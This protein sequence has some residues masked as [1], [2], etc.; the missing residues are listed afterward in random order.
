MARGAGRQ[1][2]EGADPA[3]SGPVARIGGRLV[4]TGSWEM[5]RGCS[6]V[7]GRECAW[8]EMAAKWWFRAA[9]DCSEEERRHCWEGAS[10]GY[11]RRPP[12]CFHPPL[13]AVLNVL[14]PG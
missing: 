1:D 8:K 4:T 9:D 7:A 5:G 3:G 2:G 13:C 11:L 14:E 6:G 10:G 12:A